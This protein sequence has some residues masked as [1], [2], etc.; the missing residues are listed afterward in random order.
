MRWYLKKL[1]NVLCPIQ[2][3]QN[4]PLDWRKV[5]IYLQCHVIRRHHLSKG[6]KYLFTITGFFSFCWSAYIGAGDLSPICMAPFHRP[7]EEEKEY[8][9]ENTFEGLICD[10]LCLHPRMSR[11]WVVVSIFS[12]F[13]CPRLHSGVKLSSFDPAIYQ[14]AL[15]YPGEKLRNHCAIIDGHLSW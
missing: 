10:I 4:C 14:E 1:G 3:R 6:C 12:W 7:G 15:D 9:G 8:D 13:H 5:G 11:N 2:T